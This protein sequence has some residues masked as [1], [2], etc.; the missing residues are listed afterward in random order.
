M[1]FCVDSFKF[2]YNT[3]S[4]EFQVLQMA[5]KSNCIKCIYFTAIRAND[6]FGICSSTTQKPSGNKIDC[7]DFVAIEENSDY[8]PVTL[9]VKPAKPKS[10]QPTSNFGTERITTNLIS[11][12][13]NSSR[14]NDLEPEEIENSADYNDSDR[15]WRSLPLGGNLDSTHDYEF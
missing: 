11:I 5:Q 6:E 3:S 1:S 10:I 9:V 12:S 4:V 7:R 15:D 2:F 8:K 13:R 14:I